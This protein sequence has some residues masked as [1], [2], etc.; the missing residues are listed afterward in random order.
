M[1][2]GVGFGPGREDVKKVAHP[3]EKSI[4]ELIR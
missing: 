3:S 4:P 1:L 2:K